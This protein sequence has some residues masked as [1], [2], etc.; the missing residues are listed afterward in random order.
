LYHISI[1]KIPIWV[2]FGGPW[3]GTGGIF[4]GHLIG[5][6]GIVFSPALVYVLY[7][8]KSG[9]LAFDT[10]AGMQKDRFANVRFPSLQRTLSL[11]Q[12]GPV[13]L[14][15][16]CPPQPEPEQVL[17]EDR[18]ADDERQ[19]AEGLPVGHEPRQDLQ[20]GRGGGKVVAKG[21]HGHQ[22]GHAYAR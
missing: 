4:Y 2:Y 9:N 16:L 8:E 21:S 14:E 20:D 6:V 12:N 17:R 3:N 1:P 15:E 5:C 10:D 19:P 13:R 18:E 11:L 7:R 22:E